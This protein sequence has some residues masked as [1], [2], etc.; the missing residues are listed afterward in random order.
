MTLESVNDSVFSLSYI[1]DIAIIAFKAINKIFALKGAIPDCV[2]GF[3]FSKSL[4]ISDW[5]ILL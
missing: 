5:K 4:I 2:V 1:F 3:S